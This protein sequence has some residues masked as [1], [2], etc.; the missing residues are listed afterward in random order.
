MA[1]DSRGHQ[2]FVR[3]KYWASV[4]AFST[5]G[6]SGDIKASVQGKEGPLEELNALLLQGLPLLKNRLHFLHVAWA[7]AIKLLQSLFIAF[8]HLLKE[9][10]GQDSVCA[11]GLL[12]SET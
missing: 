8:T 3:A 1:S 6:V 9:V 2:A 10:K 11:N 7:A 12:L 4:N 5:P